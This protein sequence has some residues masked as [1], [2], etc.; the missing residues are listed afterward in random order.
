LGLSISGAG[1]VNGDGY[2]DIIIGDTLQFSDVQ[3]GTAYVIYGGPDGPTASATTP[4]HFASDAG[5][6]LFL[7]DG[8]GY[9]F[10]YATGGGGDFNGDG[11][12]DV[13]IGAPMSNASVSV[14]FGSV[15]P[16]SSPIEVPT[17]L[18]GSN[19]FV[20]AI[21]QAHPDRLGHSITFAGDINGDGFDDIIIG[22]PR[23]TS[24]G[25]SGPGKVWI[26][27]GS[28]DPQSAIFD[29]ADIDGSNGFELI[30]SAWGIQRGQ[31]GLA[32]AGIDINGDGFADIVS[33][34]PITVTADGAIAQKIYVVF[35]GTDPMPATFDMVNLNG[36]N[37]FQ[38]HVRHTST[39]TTDVLAHTIGYSLSN[40]GDINGDGIEDLVFTTSF[41]DGSAAVLFGSR[42]GFPAVVDLE[43]LDGTNGFLVT[44]SASVLSVSN[45]G[46]VNGDGVD[47]LIVG[48]SLVFG[49]TSGFAA[50]VDASA[51]DGTDGYR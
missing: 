24:V 5:F 47:D 7:T 26:V 35:G 38:I 15:T 49:T 31:I 50:T 22:Q 6:E 29:L 40:A 28:A 12:D 11:L 48:Q 34:G 1:D 3:D 8:V 27:F 17:E 51:L 21:P 23:A 20:V 4:E 42:T 39:E 18:D 45:A 25:S 19:G 46:D 14:V 30:D 37:G 41:A 36:A 16:P 33:S 44:A 13:I 2:D 32:V 43:A 10:G 9:L